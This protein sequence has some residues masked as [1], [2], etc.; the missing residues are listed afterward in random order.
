MVA[1]DMEMPK[2]RSECPC[3]AELEYDVV[4]NAKEG[5]ILSGEPYEKRRMPFCPLVE[6][7]EGS[8]SEIP[9]S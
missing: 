3:C 8:C 5:H 4:C 6:L 9:N 2:S 7:P 1:I